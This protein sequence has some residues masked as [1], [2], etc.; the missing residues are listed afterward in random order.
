MT[1]AGGDQEWGIRLVEQ[2]HLP[3]RRTLAKNGI[4]GSTRCQST[5]GPWFPLRSAWCQTQLGFKHRLTG[6]GI[7]QD[8]AAHAFDR[9][10][11]AMHGGRVLVLAGNV[12]QRGLLAV[13][14]P[15][16]FSGLLH[17]I[18][19]GSVLPVIVAPAKNEAVLAQMICDRTAKPVAFRLST[20]VDECRA[21]CQ[22]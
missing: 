11:R 12:P 16:A 14:R 22:T 20:T 1:G 2:S 17:R 5:P 4:P 21:P 9:L 18:P 19:A 13:A 8:R 6:A 7:V 15:M 10:L 3:V